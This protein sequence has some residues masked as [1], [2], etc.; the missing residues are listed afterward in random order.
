[1][2]NRSDDELKNLYNQYLLRHAATK[3]DPKLRDISNQ[4]L[5]VAFAYG[6]MLGLGMPRI[7]LDINRAISKIEKQSQSSRESLL[8]KLL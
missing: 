6:R 1:M 5:G 2:T 8:Q 7:K 3:S 4:L